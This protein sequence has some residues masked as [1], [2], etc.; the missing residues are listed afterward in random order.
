MTGEVHPVKFMSD[1]GYIVF[2]HGSSVESANEAVRS[3][4][5]ELAQAGG[6]A[7]VVAAF[8]EGG[9]PDLSSAAGELVTRGVSHVVVI[10]YF[11][12]L[13]L[14]LQRDL[15]R[16]VSDARRDHPGLEIEVTPPLDG[17]PAMVEALLDRAR[18]AMSLSRT[19]EP[20][21]AGPLPV[22][23]TPEGRAGPV[24]APEPVCKPS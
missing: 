15:P 18:G 21:S 12:T 24:P 19:T 4:A 11:L 3:V 20:G 17:H 9:R 16:L 14:H 13:G 7:H 22:S 2:A 8:L 10:P 5:C 23:A 1:A 6:Y